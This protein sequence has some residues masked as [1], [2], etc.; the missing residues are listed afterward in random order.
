[1]KYRVYTYD[2]NRKEWEVEA[3]NEDEAAA[4]FDFGEPAEDDGEITVMDDYYDGLEVEFV[5][6]AEDYE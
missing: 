6:E 5:E 4:L 1:M 2:I 3:D